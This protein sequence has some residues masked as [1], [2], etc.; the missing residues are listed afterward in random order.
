MSFYNINIFA[1]FAA[2]SLVDPQQPISDY[3]T[4]SFYLNTVPGNQTCTISATNLNQITNLSITS[5]GITD[6]NFNLFPIKYIGEEVNFIVQLQ[7]ISGGNIK[8]YPLLLSSDFRFFLSGTNGNIINNNT[9]YSDFGPLSSLEQG[10]FF[11]GL[12]V[13]PVTAN[14]VALVAVLSTTDNVQLTGYSS[15]FTVYSSSGEYN[16]RKVNEDFDQTEAFKSLAFQPVLYDK[17]Q[18]FDGFLGQIVGNANSDPNTLGI[19]VYEKIANFISNNND[20][21]YCNLNQLKSLLDSVNATYQDFNYQ[22]PPSL[23]RLTDILSV[24]HKNLFGQLNQYQSN[25][26]NKGFTISPVYGL[27]KGSLLDIYTTILSGGSAVNPTNIIAYEKFSQVYTLVNTNLTNVTNYLSATNSLSSYALSSIDSSWGWDLVLPTGV[28]GVEV[29]QY[30][31]FYQY[32]PGIQGSLLQKF[33]DFNNPNNTLTITNSSYSDY[34][35]QGGI[36]DNILLYSL[37]TGLE[38]LS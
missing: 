22:Y 35:A 13:S 18:F 23:R 17:T 16:L 28:S 25:Y 10:G 5:N 27:N 31:D 29:S 32:K 20:I 15:T 14:N 9:F 1:S 30:Y 8:D 3:G 19:E 2:E 37:Y 7:N 38:V 34:I 21:D 6:G 24:K 4:V 26:D 33:I 12:F 11:K 36:I